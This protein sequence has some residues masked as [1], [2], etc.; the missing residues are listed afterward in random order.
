MTPSRPTTADPTGAHDVVVVGAGPAGALAARQLAA[1]GRDVVVIDR[2][3]FPRDK[4]CGD[5]LS[6]TAV[7]TIQA[8]GLSHVLDGWGRGSSGPVAIPRRVLDSRLLSSAVSAGARFLRASFLDVVGGDDSLGVVAASPTGE[9]VELG[10]RFLVGADGATSRVVRSA[11]G[12]RGGARNRR[13]FALRQYVRWQASPLPIR[14][15]D[16]R[17]TAWCEPHSA[18]YAWMFRIDEELANVGVCLWEPAVADAAAHL[19]EFLQDLYS[20]SGPP[21][22]TTLAR[23]GW[24]NFDLGAVPPVLED[25]IALVGDAV[26]LADPTSGEGI[27][28]ALRSGLLAA[29]AIDRALDGSDLVEYALELGREFARPMAFG[30]SRLHDGWTVAGP[31]DGFVRAE[32]HRSRAASR[33]GEPATLRMSP[34][35]VDV[36]CGDTRLLASPTGSELTEL[37]RPQT[38]VL[39]EILRAPSGHRPPPLGADGPGSTTSARPTADDAKRLTSQLLERGVLISDDE[40]GDGSDPPAGHHLGLGGQGPVRP[41][42]TPIRVAVLAPTLAHAGGLVRWSRE[43]VRSLDLVAPP[44][45]LD[46]HVIIR[47]AID[48]ARATVED[49]GLEC[50]LHEVP[51]ARANL[52]GRVGTV[53]RMSAE[54]REIRPDVV[55]VPMG[56]LWLLGLRRPPCPVVITCHS[57][58]SQQMIPRHDRALARRHARAGSAT[59]VANAERLRLPLDHAIGVTP[60][61]SITLPSG[62]DAEPVEEADEFRA[63]L[64]ESFDI[65]PDEKVVVS[66]GRIVPTKRF[67]LV[68]AVARSV[69][70]AGVPVRFLVVGD[71]PDRRAL[72]QRSIDAGLDDRVHFVGPVAEPG[73]YYLGGD[74]LLSTSDS[75]GGGPLVV[76]EALLAGLPVVA[77]DTGGAPDLLADP[78]DGRVAPC[79]DAESLARLLL[80][81]LAEPDRRAERAARARPRFSLEA[82]GKAHLELLEQL[83]GVEADYL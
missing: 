68:L 72:E 67:D 46:V 58:P 55:H 31:R 39:D 70:D 82:M 13:A 9:R 17:P 41:W 63:L 53:R 23:G 49:F 24:I 80:E 56:S 7:Q 36:I 66:V 73:G 69:A 45:R 14:P 59:L 3:A 33:P 25:R 83:V 40:V 10:T 47:H 78:L 74:A 27:S 79:G 57:F 1:T 16:F 77:T 48:R 42:S 50:S 81:S 22:D 65:G 4:S 44:G 62:T 75:E 60:G 61:T 11:W 51:V 32:T 54:L 26:G 76:I 19:D 12:H 15:F 34:D 29:R 30:L 8:Q 38:E 64:R 52:R 28:H 18:S 2:S 21:I 20:E 37:S 71:G 5:L 6:R 35:V 43:L